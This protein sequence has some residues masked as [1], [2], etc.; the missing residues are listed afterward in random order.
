MAWEAIVTG[1]GIQ[2]DLP[3]LNIAEGYYHYWGFKNYDKALAVL[4]PAL[5]VYPNDAELHKLIAFVYRRA[6]RF[7][8]AVEHSHLAEELDPRSPAVLQTLGE[9]Y[10][11]L[12]DYTR[13]EQ[14]A[15]RMDRIMPADTLRHTVRA[16]IVMGRDGNPAEA[17]RLYGL[18]PDISFAQELQWTY[19]LYA[20]DFGK[21]IQVA[22]TV[23]ADNKGL[24][25]PAV[26][27][28]IAHYFAGD[29]GAAQRELESGLEELAVLREQLAQPS[30]LLLPE[31]QVRAAL[32]QVDR[33]RDVCGR[34]LEE[35]P[36][37]GFDGPTYR[38]NAARGYA[39]AGLDDLALGVLAEANESRVAPS[40][41]ELL[42]D[43]F[44]ESLHDD[45][46]WEQLIAEARP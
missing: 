33:A 3:E 22:D 30:H 35:I 1:R 32:G 15:D 46:R 16:G 43:P 31:C 9:T 18:A 14:Y 5:S 2:P 10:F 38:H 7:E 45:P 21:A 36:F 8:E 13:A 24:I 41:N 34:A 4:E 19:Y 26:G 6:G 12:G 28:G 25:T 27:R 17:A 39:L 40:R 23:T 20:R 11:R 37:D 44:L 29:P 42:L